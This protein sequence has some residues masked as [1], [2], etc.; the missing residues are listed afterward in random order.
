[1]KTVSAVQHSFVRS[2][3]SL[4]LYYCLL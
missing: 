4:T 1:V 3:V 2:F